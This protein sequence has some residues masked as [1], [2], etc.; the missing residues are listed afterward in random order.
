VV[1]DGLEHRQPSRGRQSAALLVVLI[2]IYGFYLNAIVTGGIAQP[3]DLLWPLAKVCLFS[4]APFG[5]LAFIDR[6]WESENAAPVAL[7]AWVAVFGLFSW[8]HDGGCPSVFALLFV[9]LVFSAL[10][11]HRIGALRHR[12]RAAHAG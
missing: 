2:V 6:D 10:I 11:A 5:V 4:G 8:K 1:H 3:G 12:D 7:L 9:P